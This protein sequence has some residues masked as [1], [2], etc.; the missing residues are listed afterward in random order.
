MSLKDPYIILQ[1][2]LKSQAWSLGLRS[3]NQRKSIFRLFILEELGEMSVLSCSVCLRS[4]P[5]AAPQPAE[6]AITNNSP[7]VRSLHGSPYR[8]KES[9]VSP[10]TT[11]ASTNTARFKGGSRTWL[12]LKKKGTS[13]WGACPEL[14]RAR[15]PSQDK[16][17]GCLPLIAHAI[18]PAPLSQPAE[19]ADV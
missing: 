12:G 10:S 16:V 5:M 17:S 8:A 11:T 18:C 15:L 1:A 13:Q 7:G 19:R 6:A 14:V 2:L 4:Y 3:V 9:L